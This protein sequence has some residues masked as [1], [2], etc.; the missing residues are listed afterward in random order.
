MTEATA[1]PD[2][3]QQAGTQ[4]GVSN[5]DVSVGDLPKVRFVTFGRRWNR[6][7]DFDVGL[8]CHFEARDFYRNR[9]VAGTTGKI[10][11]VGGTQA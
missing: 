9:V 2:H 3:P 7:E 10:K 5:S 4:I 8:D 1:S 11:L 6:P